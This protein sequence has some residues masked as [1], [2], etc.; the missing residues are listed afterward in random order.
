MSNLLKIKKD[1]TALY[2]ASVTIFGQ[3]ST[4]GGVDDYKGVHAVDVVN[5]LMEYEANA[6]MSKKILDLYNNDSDLLHAGRSDNSYN[7]GGNIDHDMQ[8]RTFKYQDDDYIVIS[9]QRYGDV[10]C[11]YTV[12]AVLKC[13]E[14]TMLYKIIEETEIYTT[15]I[16]DGKK[17][18]CCISAL[19]DSIEVTT[20][21]GRY[22]SGVYDVDDLENNIREELKDCKD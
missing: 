16:V 13:D 11:N 9:F 4:M 8:Y 7:W 15:V 10:R 2:G 19:H 5:A 6:Y 12:D 21:D 1:L 22:V 14:E 20:E 17:Y 3:P 18:D